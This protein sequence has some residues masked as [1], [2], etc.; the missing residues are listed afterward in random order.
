MTPRGVLRTS[1]QVFGN[2]VVN[3]LQSGLWGLKWSFK[4]SMKLVVEH[5][6]VVRVTDLALYSWLSEKYI[7]RAKFDLAPCRPGG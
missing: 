2:S 5:R 4:S 7:R 1:K 3:F 6:R